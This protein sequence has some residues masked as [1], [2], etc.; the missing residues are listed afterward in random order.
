MADCIFCKIVQGQIPAKKL[1][2][3]ADA[4]AI[5]D[6][7]PQAPV[8]ALVIPKHHVESLNDMT[9]DDR[10]TILPA[11]YELADQLAREKGFHGRGYRTVV[12]NQAD[13]GQTVF[14]LHMHVLGGAAMKHGFGS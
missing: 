8:H 5:A 13:G 12:N 14:H 9:S 1:A 10:R 11:L 7:N 3:S 2:E 6:I 4:I